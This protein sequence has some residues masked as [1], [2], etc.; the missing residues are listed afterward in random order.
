MSGKKG[1][2]I[3]HILSKWLVGII[4]LLV[5]NCSVDTPF[6][7]VSMEWNGSEYVEAADFNDIES[8]YELVAECC[9]DMNDDFVP[10]NDDDD[11]FEIGKTLKDWTCRELPPFRYFTTSP[12]VDYA[13][14]AGS[15]FL[16]VIREVTAP[17]PDACNV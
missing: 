13:E 15:S 17:P 12:S 8:L 6:D 2:H 9:L 1:S 4:A 11:G 3:K 7:P 14:Y 5:L 10:E 16:S